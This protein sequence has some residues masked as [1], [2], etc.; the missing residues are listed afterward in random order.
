MML[1]NGM[2]MTGWILFVFCVRLR[3][4][5]CLPLG[6]LTLAFLAFVEGLDVGQEAPGYGFDFVLASDL[7]RIFLSNRINL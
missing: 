4:L 2:S 1:V 3:S 7:S 5:L 6:E